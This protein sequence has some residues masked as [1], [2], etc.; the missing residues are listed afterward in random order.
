[1]ILNLGL[2]QGA[3]MVTMPRFDLEPCLELLE[4]AASPGVRRAPGRARAGQAPAGRR[5]DL[6]A[7]EL[8]PLR[9]RAARRRPRAGLRRAPRP[10][11]AQGYG[12]TECSPVTHSGPTGAARA[13]RS[14]CRAVHGVPHRRP[15]DGRG[16]RHGRAWRALGARPAGHAGLPRTPDATP[17][18]SSTAGCAPATWRWSTATAGLIVDRVKELIKYKGFQVAPAELEALL[19][20]HPGGRRRGG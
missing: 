6:S 4:D 12:M 17:R 5:H 16:S 1:M 18:R 20:A 2:R 15:R 9:C 7:L 11:V 14:G 10:R 19:V 8:D 3:T 13:A